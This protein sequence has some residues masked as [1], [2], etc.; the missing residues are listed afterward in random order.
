MRGRG[1]RFGPPRRCGPGDGRSH[2][3]V[4]DGHGLV[5]VVG[6]EQHRLARLLSDDALQL[7]LQPLAGEAVERERARPSAAR[8]ARPRAPA[9]S[10]RAGAGRRR[11]WC[12][13]RS[14]NRR[15]D[16]PQHRVR[17]ARRCA[18]DRPEPSR[19]KATLSITGARAAGARPGTP[20]PSACGNRAGV[21]L[22]RAAAR[23]AQIHQHPQEGRLAD[24]GLATMTRTSP[25]TTRGRGRRG[26]RC[27]A[28]PCRRRG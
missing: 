6:D 8:R 4:G 15:G 9:R 10:R 2:D 26:R 28:R 20:S 11:G 24:A 19:P 25:R 16:Q 7:V 23:A 22:H 13:Q 17:R 1:G 27:G 12:G 18:R 5:D 14:R 21:D 3:P